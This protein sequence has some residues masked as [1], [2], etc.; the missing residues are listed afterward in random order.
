MNSNLSR[1]SVKKYLD[2]LVSINFLDSKTK[3][4]D[5]GRPVTIFVKKKSED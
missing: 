3:F 5:I 2:Y 4:L 1:V